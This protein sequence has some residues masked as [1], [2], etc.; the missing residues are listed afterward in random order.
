[1]QDQRWLNGK[2]EIKLRG[3]KAE[4]EPGKFIDIVELRKGIRRPCMGIQRENEFSEWISGKKKTNR[5]GRNNS[6]FWFVFN[7]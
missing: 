5:K 4:E 2:L 7:S 3:I 1:M 6:L